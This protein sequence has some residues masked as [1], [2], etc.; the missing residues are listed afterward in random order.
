MDSWEIALLVVAVVVVVVA[1]IF[2]FRTGR[3]TLDSLL[4]RRR[5]HRQYV[6]VNPASQF[7]RQQA[8]TQLRRR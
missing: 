1:L 8:Q 5:H 2:L 4:G 6:Y 3:I 7:K